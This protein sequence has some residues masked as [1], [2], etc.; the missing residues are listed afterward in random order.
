MT[1]YRT[2]KPFIRDTLGCS[3]GNTINDVYVT[4]PKPLA[5][6]LAPKIIHDS[7]L[8]IELGCGIGGDTT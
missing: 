4:T 6:A 8:V 3:F 5:E 2:Y 1:D 7:K